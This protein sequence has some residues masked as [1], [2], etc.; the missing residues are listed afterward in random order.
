MNGLQV[1][2]LFQSIYAKFKGGIRD[3]CQLE[4]AIVF[5]ARS[6]I[7][8]GIVVGEQLDEDPLKWDCAGS[9]DLD[10][11]R[12]TDATPQS[13]RDGIDVFATDLD[14]LACLVARLFRGML[15]GMQQIATRRHTFYL[16]LSL[17]VG[18]GALIDANV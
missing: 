18:C 4:G 7:R 5:H 10:S 3:I 14:L 17:R 6:C 13:K 15:L 8:A 1:P 11:P 12:D 2:I 16:E 9:G